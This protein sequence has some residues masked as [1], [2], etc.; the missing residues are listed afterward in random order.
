MKLIAS[1]LILLSLLNSEIK[2]YTL[3]T[4]SNTNYCFNR[5]DFVTVRNE[6]KNI[7]FYKIKIYD[8]SNKFMIVSNE[9]T[10][11]KKQIQPTEKQIIKEI[12]KYAVITIIILSFIAGVKVGVSI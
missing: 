1:F 3:I 2:P 4:K 11:L 6:L 12:K 9:N 10:I 7:E 8:Y 5:A